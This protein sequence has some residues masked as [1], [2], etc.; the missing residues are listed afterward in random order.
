MTRPPKPATKEQLEG[1][2]QRA[3]ANGGTGS[4]GLTVIERAIARGFDLDAKGNTIETGYGPSHP[5][6]QHREQE[7][8]DAHNPDLEIVCSRAHKRRG[9][10]RIIAQFWRVPTS[11]DDKPDLHV[12]TDFKEGHP[13]VSQDVFSSGWWTQDLHVPVWCRQHGLV[14]LPMVDL[15]VDLESTRRK[16]EHDCLD[17]HTAI[18]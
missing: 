12:E 13:T 8:L 3:Q 4:D 10:Q 7:W 15:E 2:I 1:L 14:Q 18:L 9:D 6:Y 16:R 11:E 17:P 5:E